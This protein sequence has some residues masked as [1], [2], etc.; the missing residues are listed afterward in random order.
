MSP[1]SSAL[2]TPL[3]RHARKTAMRPMWPSGRSRPV[4][5]GTPSTNATRWRDCASSSSH[6]IS[7]GTDC[8]RM[9]T[10]VRSALRIFRSTD[11]SAARTENF[12]DPVIR[13]ASAIAAD[14]NGGSEGRAAGDLDDRAID[15]AGLV[16]S[17]E[18]VGIGDLFRLRQAPQRHAIDHGLHYLLR[19]GF[20]DR[21]FDETPADRVGPAALAPP[22]PRPGFSLADEAELARC[23]VGLAAIT[24][25][26][27]H[28]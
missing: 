10:S 6:S 18:G 4:P 20:Q 9:K 21:C 28:P 13:A 7:A 1:V 11:Q 27:D 15:V 8:S 3:P 24:V 22:F 17:K 19:D 25:E 5:I 23:I 26:A 2:T 16:G 12:S 14:L